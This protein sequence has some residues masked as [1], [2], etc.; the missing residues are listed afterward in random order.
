MGNAEVLPF[1]DCSFE[2]VLSRLAFHHFPNRG[3]PFAE[4]VRVLKPG[5]KLVIIDMEAAEEPLRA[6]EDELEQMRDPSHVRNLSL[7]EMQEMYAY[8]GMTIP[9]CEMT[10]IPVVL[11]NWLDLTQTPSDI[12]KEITRRLQEELQ[13]GQKTG[14]YPYCKDEK[15]G[16]DHRWIL[17]IGI[18]AAP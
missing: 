12:Q 17:L 2:I 5:G 1:P 10:K 4:M 18:K 13:G 11:Q 15:I 8:Y 3:K 7:A 6:V 9:I 14:F 16:F